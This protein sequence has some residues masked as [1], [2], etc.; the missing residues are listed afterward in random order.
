M[1]DTLKPAW[2][3]DPTKVVPSILAPDPRA[4]DSK[5]IDVHPPFMLAK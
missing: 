4:L 1:T 3:A 5:S 2:G